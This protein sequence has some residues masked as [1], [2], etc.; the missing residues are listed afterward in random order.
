MKAVNVCK[1]QSEE[2]FAVMKAEFFLQELV[3]REAQRKHVE[4]RESFDRDVKE[5]YK[6]GVVCETCQV[7]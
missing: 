4:V 7:Y 6:V 5:L 1:Y 2:R 3:Y